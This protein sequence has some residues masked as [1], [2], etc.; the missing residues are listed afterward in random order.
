M[1]G[2]PVY[3][4]YVIDHTVGRDDQPDFSKCDSIGWGTIN[5]LDVNSTD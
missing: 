3:V 4:A 1:K 2:F 5:D